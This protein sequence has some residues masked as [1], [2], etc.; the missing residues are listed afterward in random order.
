MAL[1]GVIIDNACIV[2]VGSCPQ[3]ECVN[4]NLDSDTRHCQMSARSPRGSQRVFRTASLAPHT[5]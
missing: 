2:K 4:G 1:K 3:V 5:C